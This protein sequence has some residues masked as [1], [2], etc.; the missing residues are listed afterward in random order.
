MRDSPSLIPYLSSL[1]PHLSMNSIRLIHWNAEEAEER[2]SRLSAAGYEADFGPITPKILR[3]MRSSLPA[4]VVI[5]L[6][7]LPS[8]GRDVAL[9]IRKNAGTRGVP[10]VFVD[11]NPEKVEGVKRHLPDATYTTWKGI[12]G[13]LK[14]A[15]SSAPVDPV[16][17]ESAMAGYSGTPLLKKLG[18]K[19][20]LT[21]SLVK[22]PDDFDKT[23]GELPEGV[24][25]RKG[26]RG[27]AN[28]TI[29][30]V[31]SLKD[32]MAGLPKM[33]PR[34]EDAGLW[35]AWPKKASGVQTDVTQNDVR[36]EGLAAGM[37]DFKICSIDETWSGLKFTLRK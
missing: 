30:F 26:I 2:S 13:A 24:T 27:K 33:V 19:P 8:Q 7:R 15:I 36:R 25:V 37:V 23:L 16:V 3:A 29:W 4:A 6:S 21:V 31:R 9:T 28:L 18:I 11:G 35:I 10:I 34:S 17:P 14:T 12:K 20:G 22:P 1:I 5:D 32:L